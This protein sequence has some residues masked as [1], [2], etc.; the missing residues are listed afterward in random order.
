MLTGSLNVL[1]WLSYVVMMSLYAFAF[2]SYGSTFLPAAWH[3]TGK[4]VLISL[5]VILI[6]GLN[7]LSAEVIGKAENWIVGLK[8]AILLFFVGVGF[9]GIDVSRV[10]T[11]SWSPSLQLAAGG[12]IIF[13]AYEGFELIANTAHDVRDV[14]RTLPRAYFTAVGFVLALYVL[15][16]LVTVGNLPVDT[17]VAA[18]DYALAEAARPFLG[19]GRFYAYCDRSN[20]IN[21]FGDQ[22]NSIR[23]GSVELLY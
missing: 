2:G 13:L 15:V 7:L 14:A 9:A 19:H 12:T 21:S 22:C 20:V 3:A 1:L 23:L 18:K 10:V 6:A 8:I 5:S 11:G 4:H 17:I 16:S